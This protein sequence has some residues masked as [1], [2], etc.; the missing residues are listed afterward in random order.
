MGK[1]REVGLKIR[2]YETQLGGGVG[3]AFISTKP[4]SR[5]TSALEKHDVGLVESAIQQ[6]NQG[7]GPNRQNG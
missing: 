3:R 7:G 1:F 5:L 2:R 4:S 6:T